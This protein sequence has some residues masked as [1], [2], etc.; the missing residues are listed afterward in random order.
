MQFTRIYKLTPFKKCLNYQN[1][2]VDKTQKDE[3]VPE[4]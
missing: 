2:K 1:L 3:N 4:Y